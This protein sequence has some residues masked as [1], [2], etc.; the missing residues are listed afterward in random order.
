[1]VFRL[2]SAG[3]MAMRTIFARETFISRMIGRKHG[4]GAQ[5]AEHSKE[6]RSVG[7]SRHLTAICAGAFL[8][9]SG[10]NLFDRDIEGGEIGS[11]RMERLGWRLP[12]HALDSSG[13]YE[14]TFRRHRAATRPARF[15]Y[16]PVLQGVTIYQG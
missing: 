10:S 4:R 16:Y 5:F 14:C 2:S 9:E 15:N 1:M 11:K 13:R 12:Q 8:I 3:P 7:R 6:S